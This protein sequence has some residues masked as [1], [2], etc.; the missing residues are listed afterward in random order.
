MSEEQK[1]R[2]VAMLRTLTPEQRAN[3]LLAIADKA[4]SKGLL[5]DILKSVGE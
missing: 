2:I 3:I 1:A 4:I 5:A